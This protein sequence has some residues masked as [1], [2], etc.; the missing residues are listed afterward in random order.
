MNLRFLSR[1][2]LNFFTFSWSSWRT[3]SG[4]SQRKTCSAKGL[5]FK[6]TPVCSAYLSSASKI[7]S[8]LDIV[9]CIWKERIGRIRGWGRKSKGQTTKAQ[10]PT[11]D[12]RQDR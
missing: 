7:N 5:S 3:A 11:D 4:E 9:D 6:L 8:R 10:A 12:R 1:Y 2:S